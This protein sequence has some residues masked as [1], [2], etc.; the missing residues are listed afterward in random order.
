MAYTGS[1]FEVRIHEA[2][3][4][5]VEHEERDGALA[6]QLVA[7]AP[8]ALVGAH[9]QTRGGQLTYTRKIDDARLAKSGSLS[10]AERRGSD[11]HSAL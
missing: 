9:A 1:R 3:R 5:E 10:G 2:R 4:L 6:E 8:R 7:S 11:Q